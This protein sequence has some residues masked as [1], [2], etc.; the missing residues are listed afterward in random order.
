MLS[1]EISERA[2]STFIYFTV[3]PCNSSGFA[4]TK[5]NLH[6]RPSPP[7]GRLSYVIVLDWAVDKGLSTNVVRNLAIGENNMTLAKPKGIV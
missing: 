7:V 1:S 6:S 5:F 4:V 2:C 3:T